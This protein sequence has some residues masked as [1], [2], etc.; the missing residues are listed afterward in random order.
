[1]KIKIYYQHTDSSNVVYYAQYLSF[2][3]EARTEFLESKGFT[4]KKLADRGIHFVVAKQSIDYES[5]A[6]YA[7]ILDVRSWVSDSTAVRLIFDAE[8]K[9]QNGRVVATGKT[10]LVCVDETFKPKA[11]GE[12]FRE[13]L[14]S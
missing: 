3:E 7:D 11:L 6:Y 12:D 8:V 14:T 4:M 9:N 1:M 5:P 13:K 10:T 2:F